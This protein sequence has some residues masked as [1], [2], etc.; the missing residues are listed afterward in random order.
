MTDRDITHLC[1]ELQLIAQVWLDDCEAAG[2]NV[3]IIETYRSKVEQDALY[4]Q[5]RTSPGKI[6]THA[7]GGHSPHECCLPDGT[8]ASK[9]FDYGVFTAAGAYISDGSDPR[10]AE[11]GRIGK[12]LALEYGGDWPHPKTDSDHLQLPN[13]KKA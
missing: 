1:Q 8:P 4:A 12:A 7:P 5:G 10:Y 3:R 11:A 13:W 9:A 6:V 2:L